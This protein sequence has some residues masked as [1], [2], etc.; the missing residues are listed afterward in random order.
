[1]SMTKNDEL[2][3]IRNATTEELLAEL[4]RRDYIVEVRAMTENDKKRIQM[5]SE[6]INHD[7]K[8]LWNQ[9]HSVL[10]ALRNRYGCM[11]ED[12][13][14]TYEDHAW[15]LYDD[16][17]RGIELKESLIEL[18]DEDYPEFDYDEEEI[19]EVIAEYE[20]KEEIER[21]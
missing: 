4:K 14:Y 15:H 1:M 5:P 21:E 18:L 17:K 2:E 3:A 6:T 19:T 16:V 9:I 20:Q 8:E 11:G 13:K 7:D 10:D 12:D